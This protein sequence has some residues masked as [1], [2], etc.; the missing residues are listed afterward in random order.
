MK[1][2]DIALMAFHNLRR[3]PVRTALNLFGITLGT[4]IILLTAAGGDGVKKALYALIENSGHATEIQVVADYGD[5]AEPN[6]SEWQITGE[7]SEERR[8]RMEKALKQLLIER[9]HHYSAFKMIDSKALARMREIENVTAVVPNVSIWFRLRSD[10]FSKMLAGESTSPLNLNLSKRMLAGQPLQPDEVDGILIH[11]LLA[12]QMGYVTDGEVKRLVGKEITAEF[13]S[14]GR[15]SRGLTYAFGSG[16]VLDAEQQFDDETKLLEA[17][18]KLIGDVDLS[19]LTDEQ[20]ELI[21]SSL[22]SNGEH[23]ELVPEAMHRRTFKI[24]G[25]FYSG[26]DNPFN[27]FRNYFASFRSHV[28][29][30]PVAATDIQ[31]NVSQEDAFYSCAVSAGA[32]S[33]GAS[34]P[35]VK[36]PLCTRSSLTYAKSNSCR[37]SCV[38]IPSLFQPLNW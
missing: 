3:R 28:L 5:V 30:H 23:D 15:R 14:G 10:D 38:G 21:R 37:D 24:K 25:V 34:S 16:E 4:I 35:S 26:K 2:I 7:M 1:L 33:T 27:L 22:I 17:M 32:S 9:Q 8:Q 13:R 36:M 19:S 12:Y 31:L 20:K 18:K 29:F 6:E 11:E